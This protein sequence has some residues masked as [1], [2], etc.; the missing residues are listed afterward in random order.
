MLFLHH[1]KNMDVKGN[2]DNVN[3]ERVN[4]TKQFAIFFIL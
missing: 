4:E 1:D 2:I 3:I